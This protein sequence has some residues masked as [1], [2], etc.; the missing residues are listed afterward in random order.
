MNTRLFV[1]HFLLLLALT[2]KA[3]CA[4]YAPEQLRHDLKQLYETLQ[5]SHYDL[6]AYVPKAMFDRAYQQAY[7]TMERPM[8][9]LEA[10]RTLQPLATLAGMGHCS[11]SLPFKAAY[12]PYVMK[13][14]TLLPFD[15]TFVGDQAFIWHTYSDRPEL[16]PGTRLLEIGGRPVANVLDDIGRFVAGD[17]L[18]LKRTNIEMTG[19]A[20][21]YWLTY[22]ET[23]SYALT[24]QNSR[25]GRITIDVSAVPAL[26]VEQ[27]ASTHRPITSPQRE[28]R[29]HDEVAYLRPGIF[30]N[31]D[32]SANL[33]NH[34]TFEKG[35][36][37][38]FL[39]TAFR[40]IRENQS[41][42]L[43]IDLR[44]NPG[45][46]N[47]FS[48]PLVA[49]IADR[50]FRFC[51][52]FSVRTSQ[53]TKDFWAGVKDPALAGLRSALMDRENGDRFEFEL[54]FV[55]PRKEEERFRGRVFLLVDRFTYS[56]A[57]TTAAVF[58]DY[59]FGILVGQPTADVPTTYAAA[60]SF[61]LLH[62]Q[63]TVLYPKALMVRPSGDATFRGVRPDHEV[64]DDVFTD[65][66]EILMRA[67]ELA[68]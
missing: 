7:D 40:R 32:A 58:Q 60:H 59:R 19:F 65:R 46:D 45:G 62:T 56:N 66:D 41:R 51:S 29:F 28:I 21:L 10:Y 9:D 31:Q 64:A 44:G 55:Q 6:F 63:L 16:A 23:K 27:K 14:G 37:I 54:P 1:W 4:T 2:S 13:G 61:N 53:V 5:D 49:Y 34:Q 25:G 39:E 68:R 35:E 15:L 57:V 22:G 17:S 67:L 52:R 33:A 47:A 24:L 18:Y 3:W 26:Q 30:L 20:R 50:S 42:C 48:D 38:Q 12:V 43:I 8:D 11:I 36:F